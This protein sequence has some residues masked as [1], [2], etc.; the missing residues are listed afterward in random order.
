MHPNV[1]R[2]ALAAADLLF[3]ERCSACTAIVRAGELFCHACHAGVNVLGPPECERCGQ[4][5]AAGGTCGPCAAAPEPPIRRARAWAAYHGSGDRQPVAQAL[6]AF[7]YRG[8]RRLARRLAAAMLA[9]V[10]PD[11]PSII[12]PIP[13]HP[14][15]L[16]RRGFNQSA[17]LARLVG[18]ALGRRVALRLLVRVRDTPS[19]TA[20]SAAARAANVAGAFA[21][22]L[23]AEVDGRSV[24]LIDD[25][26]TSGSTA[27]AAAVALRQAGARAVDVL[28]FA[29]VL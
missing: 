6:A 24:L 11:P 28:T 29:R 9:R 7:K 23:P 12:A 4:P 16:R 26:W 20:L 2:A 5:L 27:G 3:P 1:R 21:V 19:Q 15:Q 22:R 8:A 13:L 18:R 14:N 17:V 25:V 10:P